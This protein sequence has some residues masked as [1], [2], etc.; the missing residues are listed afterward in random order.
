MKI[1]RHVKQRMTRVSAVVAAVA[2]LTVWSMAP[3]QAGTATL[4]RT[5]YLTAKPT[6]HDYAF[7]NNRS[8]YLEA[9]HYVFRVSLFNEDTHQLVPGSRG[10]RQIWLDADTY[11]WRCDIG[12]LY[13]YVYLAGCDLLNSRGGMARVDSYDFGIGSNGTFTLTGHLISA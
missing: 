4:S 11:Q 9:G 8:I 13:G 7:T 1:A 10:E 6:A 12:G 5:L 3:A 2:A